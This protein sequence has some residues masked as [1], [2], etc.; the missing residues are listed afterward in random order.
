MILLTEFFNSD[1]P[2]RTNEIIFCIKENIKNKYI[3]KIYLFV[4]KHENIPDEILNEKI[5]IIR[6]SRPTYREFIKYGNGLE[7]KDDLI[8]IANS[9]ILFDETLKYLYDLD[10]SNVFMGLT[11]HDYV[12]KEFFKRVSSQDCWIFKKG[13]KE[14]Y[15]AD[16]KLGTY[17]CD[18]RIF[19]IYHD[20]GY[21]VL[22]PSKK[23]KIWHYHTDEYRNYIGEVKGSHCY[24]VPADEVDWDPFIILK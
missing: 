21:Q 20:L 3:E 17:Y 5:T 2:N 24:V 6:G 13:L 22:N 11:R 9:D 19:R 15:K 4:E 10:M 16:F 18:S 14:D 8:I 12:T 1:R 23:I 7:S